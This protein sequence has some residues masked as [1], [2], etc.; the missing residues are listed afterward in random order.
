VGTAALLLVYAAVSP[1]GTVRGQVASL[2]PLRSSG[3]F[4]LDHQRLTIPPGPAQVELEVRLAG[5]GAV[6]GGPSLGAYQV[7]LDPTGYSGGAGE[8]IVPLGWPTSPGD[9]A[10]IAERICSSSGA[11]C[12]ASSDCGPEGGACVTRPDY[13]FADLFPITVLSTGSLAYVF[14][15]LVA[16][17][18]PADDGAE[19]YGGTLILAV[20]PGASGE[21]IVG[22]S[23]DDS[24]TFLNDCT[25]AR[26]AGLVTLPAV[27]TVLAEGQCTIG[28]P[29]DPCQTDC[30]GN[31]LCD[32]C[33]LSTGASEDCN[34]N[35]V[36]DRCDLLSGTSADCDLSGVPDE[37]EA[38]CNGNGL[39]DLCDILA[40][41]SIDCNFNTIP[42]EC[43]PDCQPNGVADECDLAQGT[44][45]DCTANGVPDECEP[46]CQPNA[47][48]DPCEILE[49]GAE[50]CDG[51]GVPDDCQPDCQPNGVADACDV[52]AGASPDCNGNGVPDECDED[53]DGSGGPDDCESAEVPVI[54]WWPVRADTLFARCGS[55]M[56]V[57][58]GG[59]RVE[60]ELRVGRWG[61]APGSPTLG[62]YQAALDTALLAGGHPINVA[63]GT[64]PGVDLHP[65][66]GVHGGADGVFISVKTCAT[67]GDFVST[68][69][70]CDP[71]DPPLPPCRPGELC[72]DNPDFVFSGMVA[73]LAVSTSFAAWAA[74]ANLPCRT[75]DGADSYYAGTLIVD[76]PAAAQGTYTLSFVGTEVATFLNDCAG[77][78]VDGVVL[79]SGR[80][81]IARCG[82]GLLEP[83]EA[84][85]DGNTQNR[86]GCAS[87][88]HV[89]PTWS[90]TGEPSVCVTSCGDGNGEADEQCD[91]SNRLDGDGCSSACIYEPV[92][93]VDLA[94][95]PDGLAGDEFGSSVALDGWH[96]ISGAPG[97]GT[98]NSGAAYIHERTG[99]TW[100][101]RRTLAGTGVSAGDHFGSSVA[102]GGDRAAVGAPRRS[103]GGAV[104]LF[105]RLDDSW[106][107][108]DVLTATDAGD[109]DQFGVSV[110]LED[111]VVVVGA[112]GNDDACNDDDGCD[113][114][115]A[116]VFRLTGNEWMHEAKLAAGDA[117]AG[118]LFGQTVAIDGGRVVVGSPRDDDGG[119]SSG[120]AYVFT[121][122]GEGWIQTAK[123]IASD[124][125]NNVE[126]GRSVAA[127]GNAV[128]VGAWLEDTRG[129]NAG[130]AYVYRLAGDSWVEDAKLV[131]P[132]SAAHDN[133]GTA[134]AIYANTIV[135]AAPGNDAACPQTSTCNSGTAFLFR[136]TEVG[137]SDA[138]RLTAPEAAAG[139]RFGWSVGL[140]ESH[141]VIGGRGVDRGLEVDAGVSFIFAVD[142]DCNDNGIADECDLQRGLSFDDDG[143]EIPDECELGACCDAS[144]GCAL[145]AE[146][147][148]PSGVWSEG[149]ACDPNPCP[150]P[151][152]C[153]AG[154]GACAESLEPDCTTGAWTAGRPCVPNP[155]PK[156]GSCCEADGRCSVTFDAECAAGTWTEGAGCEPIP[157]PQPGACCEPDGSC[158]VVLE[159]ECGSGSWAEGQT[160][161]PNTC[162]RP[163][164]CCGADG[165]C[166]FVLEAECDADLW[167]VGGRCEPNRCPQPGACCRADGACE[168]TFL[169]QCDDGTWTEHQ[170]CVPNACPQ[171]G[172]CCDSV[173]D[174][175]VAP[176]AACGDI[177]WVEGGACEPNPCSQPGA[178]CMPDGAC[179]VVLEAEC[180]SGQWR[181]GPFC[182]PNTCRPAVPPPLRAPCPFDHPRNRYI[183]F[184]T[185]GSADDGRPL[186][187]QV[188]LRSLIQGSCSGNGAPC[189]L[190]LGDA[191]CG[192][193]SVTRAPCIEAM[194]DCLPPDQA[195]VPSG[196]VC[197]NDH[198]RSIGRRWWV[199]PASRLGNDVHLLVSDA[200]SRRVSDAWPV[201]VHVGDCE[202]VPQ[203]VYGVSSVDVDTGAES[204]W[205]EIATAGKPADAYW[206]D[207]VGPLGFYCGGFACGP[208]C[209]PTGD[210][211][212]D[213]QPCLPDWPA[214]DGVTDF[215][216]II[217][218]VFVFER[219]P[220]RPAPELTRVDLH[221]DDDG[222][223]A[224]DPPNYVINFADIQFIVLAFEQRPYP[225]SDPG[226]CP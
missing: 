63:N 13:V 191:D 201:V 172:S 117:A 174:C 204:G 10:F 159:G 68:G 67:T 171:T 15:G 93:P 46:D 38:D 203:A 150:Q 145:V 219:R 142:G 197:V 51:N 124:A 111:D 158:R 57:P 193:C 156:P 52:G 108:D 41:A 104:H 98:A 207:A 23:S 194:R 127:A 209:D 167:F 71:L 121:F 84:C 214:A 5:W 166:R 62:A 215:D 198:A 97:R 64:I 173:G 210:P 182:E 69:Q 49:G 19:S 101:L 190:D 2:R 178:C 113:S 151:G 196:E 163:G 116:Y 224:V 77:R 88:C 79:Q 59:A 119:S 85:D 103:G 45:A 192:V 137:W 146:Q 133:F 128:V 154:N 222:S 74:V 184:A 212:P 141:A 33:E 24:E 131:A 58:P 199:G 225:F 216:D 31:G 78:P 18:C 181:E 25:G 160:C 34:A 138:A 213:E 143:N 217:A 123:L 132:E 4:E 134:V 90:C 169:G 114:G 208:P 29:S 6:P 155:C 220:G 32:L 144:G 55:D 185:G 14:G 94:F 39:H 20:P 17:R 176:E 73:T 136:R 9:G 126:F 11:R 70:R 115:A 200:A 202:I 168:I 21:Y 99:G 148:C 205:L 44:S 147:A 110:A 12:H 189:R 40:G 95:A 54:A 226:D 177:S 81:R 179:R 80:I 135:V 152:S 175:R 60:L 180:Q 76:V 83:G 139:D 22:F 106:I 87:T 26:L 7:T 186:A 164:R 16:D 211:C 8:P 91:D 36:P 102:I 109:L 162:P 140:G 1:G 170:A 153:C 218:A 130:A 48:P 27:L 86:D 125:A 43:E 195:C 72:V 188:E 61:T 28:S 118:D 122:G 149:L 183:S 35:R 47:V 187:Y 129:P 42:D 37:C 65:I 107:E 165:S 75:D 221:G 53:C 92:C 112:S 82:N 89:E 56:V 120:A 161:E 30:D 157:C 50:D 100:V 3:P 206:A 105:K 66:S 96:V 223:P